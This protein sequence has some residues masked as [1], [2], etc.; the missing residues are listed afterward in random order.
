MGGTEITNHDALGESRGVHRSRSRETQPG[1][2]GQNETCE[3]LT[4]KEG[5]L[6]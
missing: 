3:F 2:C 5:A 4:L 6:F 1:G